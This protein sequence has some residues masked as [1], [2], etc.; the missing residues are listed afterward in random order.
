M[1]MAFVYEELQLILIIP[2]AIQG[3]IALIT[4]IIVLR[5]SKY[6]VNRAFFLAFLAWGLLAFIDSAMYII[7]AN[8][9]FD[10]FIANILRDFALAFSN[11]TCFALLFAVLVIYR[12]KAEVTTPKMITLIISLF[13]VIFI[14]T[15]YYDSLAVINMETGAVIPAA[16]LPPSPG[17]V[18]KVTAQIN[19][20]SSIGFI[21]S[22][23]IFIISIGILAQ[24]LRKIKDPAKKRHILLFLVGLVLIFV[25]YVWF[26]V[27]VAAKFQTLATYWIGYIIWTLAPVFALM[28]VST[29]EEKPDSAECT[30]TT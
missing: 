3:T 7:A 14:F 11:I 30:S 21:A 22:L 18:F 17:V 8:S 15:D 20:F 12:G 29:P 5:K 25:G 10:L 4:A 28:G 2:K 24:L 16:T 23:S 19:A 6:I 27:I 26:F 1:A 13:L 9:E